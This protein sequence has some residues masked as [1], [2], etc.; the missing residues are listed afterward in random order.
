MKKLSTVAVLM[1]VFSAFNAT[2]D[3][4]N[5][6][7]VNQQNA[8]TVISERV[9][10]KLDNCQY[11]DAA[12]L[13]TNMFAAPVHHD[14][15][16]SVL[17][18]SEKLWFHISQG[19]TGST[20]TGNQVAQPLVRSQLLHVTSCND[21]FVCPSFYWAAHEFAKAYNEPSPDNK[22]VAFTVLQTLTKPQT[23][24]T[25]HFNMAKGQTG[26]EATHYTGLWGHGPLPCPP[27]RVEQ[28]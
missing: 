11:N 1:G 7:D 4:F 18:G 8:T 15:D 9:G 20:A 12:Q 13:V 23:T 21:G 6:V 14:M 17:C 19:N 3:E 10:L 25:Y 5:S 22:S 28:N 16:I 2:A 27:C 26:A 24:V